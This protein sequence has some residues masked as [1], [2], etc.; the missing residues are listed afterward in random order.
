MKVSIGVFI[1]V[2]IQVSCSS[3][4]KTAED[5]NEAK[6]IVYFVPHSVEELLEVE[7]KKGGNIYF[8]LWNEDSCYRVFLHHSEPGVQNP[9]ITRSNRKIFLTGKFFPIVFDFDRKFAVVDNGK[10][11][12]RKFSLDKYPTFDKS[13]VMNHG[14]YY[15][16]FDKT[17][18][19]VIQ[20]GYD[21][22]K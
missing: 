14:S 21:G 1:W 20:S 9:W 15:I 4:K 17:T 5:F 12:L 8:E 22:L 3:T 13:L 18:G 2:M 11:V 7:I 16:K 6:T 19:K 10:E